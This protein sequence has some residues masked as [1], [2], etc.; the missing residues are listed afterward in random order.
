MKPEESP[1]V[2]LGINTDPI[3][4][5]RTDDPLFFTCKEQA[6][7]YANATQWKKSKDSKFYYIAYKRKWLRKITLKLGWSVYRDWTFSKCLRV[8]QEYRTSTD[9]SQSKGYSHWAYQAACRENWLE[10]IKTKL[11]WGRSKWTYEEC[12]EIASQY[13]RAVDWAREDN[14]SYL[15]AIRK[16]WHRK[17]GKE[18]GWKYQNRGKKHNW[19]YEQCL[20]SASSFTYLEE[21]KKS[22]L[23][24]KA[25]H[26][27][28]KKR[29]W[30]IKIVEKLGW[31]V[32]P[33]KSWKNYYKCLEVASRYGTYAEFRTKHRSCYRAVL[34]FKYK[35]RLLNDMGWN[36]GEP[37]QK[38]FP[39]EH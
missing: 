38:S 24:G 15:A 9:W 2:M 31:V 35:E 7:K 10:D 28:A 26:E 8:A 21:W 5:N 25:H 33:R 17:I 32:Q 34:R 4:F 16:D 37:T 18:L 12:L 13:S 39:V 30:H 29:G 22:S 19:T 14:P 23:D 27:Y 3:P 1:N 36:I 6:E 20:E 11:G